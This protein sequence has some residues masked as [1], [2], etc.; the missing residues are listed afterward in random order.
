MVQR[1]VDGLNQQ[2]KPLANGPPCCE[3][4]CDLCGGVPVAEVQDAKDRQVALQRHAGQERAEDK[5]PDLSNQGPGG[6]SLSLG[7]FHPPY[8]CTHLIKAHVPAST[9]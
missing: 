5:S 7:I 4:L 8:F 6:A 3:C 9:T 1:G 2:V